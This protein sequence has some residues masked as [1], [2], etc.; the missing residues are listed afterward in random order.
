MCRRG[1]DVVRSAGC[2]TVPCRAGTEQD[3]TTRD[4]RSPARAADGDG[5]GR[6]V[7]ANDGNVGGGVGGVQ[8]ARLGDEWGGGLSAIGLVHV[9]RPESP[10]VAL[11]VVYRG[12]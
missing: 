10:R 3:R 4:Q 11:T 12:R 1:S 2:E 7:N 8:D 6:R 9:D 5:A